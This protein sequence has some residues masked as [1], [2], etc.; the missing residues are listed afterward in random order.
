[1][2]AFPCG[3]PPLDFVGT[4]RARRNAVPA[5]KPGSPQQLDAWFVEAGCS[6][7][8]PAPT[9][10]TSIAVDLR[11]SVYSLVA[12]PTARAATGVAGAP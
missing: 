3:T 9:R 7:A 11:E 4:R 12:A 8:R 5:E 2:H 6:T 1:M 10:P